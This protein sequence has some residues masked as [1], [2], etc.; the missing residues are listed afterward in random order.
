MAKKF[1]KVVSEFMLGR[2]LPLSASVKLDKNGLVT[3]TLQWS[4][5]GNHAR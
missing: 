5:Y 3:D 2:D 4:G 1:F